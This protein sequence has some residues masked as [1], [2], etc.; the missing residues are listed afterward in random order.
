M[1]LHR[2]NDNIEFVKNNCFSSTTFNMLCPTSMIVTGDPIRKI[3][4]T[5]TAGLNPEG[6]SSQML[7]NHGRD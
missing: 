6:V 7:H 1:G 5:L 2:L 3:Q 4:V